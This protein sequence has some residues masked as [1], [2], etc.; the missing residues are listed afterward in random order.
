MDFLLKFYICHIVIVP[1]SVSKDGGVLIMIGG[2]QIMIGGVLKNNW[3]GAHPQHPPQN[4]PM[5]HIYIYIYTVGAQ[6]IG[7]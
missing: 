5:L 4:P 6:I 1:H 2:V 7:A 3:G